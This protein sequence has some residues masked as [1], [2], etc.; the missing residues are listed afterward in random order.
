MRSGKEN[1]TYA[2]AVIRLG[3]QQHP[4]EVSCFR[5]NDGIEAAAQRER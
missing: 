4:V 1:L 3:A 2:S 5:Q